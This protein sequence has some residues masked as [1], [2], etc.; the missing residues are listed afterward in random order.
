[1]IGLNV[2]S[3]NEWDRARLK[4]L[5]VKHVR[6]SMYAAWYYPGDGPGDVAKWEEFR[7]VIVA[8]D[9]KMLAIITEPPKGMSAD[10]FARFCIDRIREFPEVEAWQILN[11]S[12]PWNAKDYVGCLLMIRTA[13][14]D[15]TLVSI[16]ME[17]PFL[18]E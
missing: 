5:G 7:E 9:L 8:D 4:E 11:E 10:D 17:E 6:A 18:R 2:H 13:L 1:M 15:V 14:P 12:C 3:L 16:A